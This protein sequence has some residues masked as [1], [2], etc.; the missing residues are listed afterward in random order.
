MLY[1]FKVSDLVVTGL[2]F[3]RPAF[4]AC[5]VCLPSA[6][7]GSKNIENIIGLHFSST[8]LIV[9]QTHTRI[10]SIHHVH[11]IYN[12]YSWSLH[13]HEHGIYSKI[14]E[15][16]NKMLFFKAEIEKP[17]QHLLTVSVFLPSKSLATGSDHQM[18]ATDEVGNQTLNSVS[19]NYLKLAAMVHE[20]WWIRKGWL[21]KDPSKYLSLSWG[22]EAHIWPRCWHA[23]RCGMCAGRK[24]L[25]HL[26]CHFNVSTDDTEARQIVIIVITETSDF[27]CD[28]ALLVFL[29]LVPH[30]HCNESR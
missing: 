7:K 1:L 10:P 12:Q 11:F 6:D 20:R 29:S 15:F 18:W 24:A 30:R 16:N 22:F 21:K 27:M 19:R 8:T 13:W 2:S 25:L 5:C 9:T 23:V 4:L 28:F 3:S 17:T 14:K 26:A